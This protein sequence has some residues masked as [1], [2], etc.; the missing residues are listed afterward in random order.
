LLEVLTGEDKSPDFAK[1]TEENRRA[2]LDIL[3]ATKAG[4]PE[5]WKD[6]A[7]LNHIRVH[8]AQTRSS[9]RPQ[10]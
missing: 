1:L 4:L 2:I 6:Y 9:Q 10:G 3:L 7:K 8:L 5:E